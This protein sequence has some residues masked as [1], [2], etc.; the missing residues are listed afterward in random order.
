MSPSPHRS[1]SILPLRRAAIAAAL[2]A[3]VVTA[4]A[5]GAEQAKPTPAPPSPLSITTITVTPAA[6]GPDTLCQLRVELRNGGDRIASELAFAVK[7]NGQEL[8][9]YRNQLF[10]QR[11]D[12]G[13]T[14]TVRLYNFW[15]TETG[16]PAPA[17]G[18]YRVEVSLLAARW[19]QVAMEKD[20]EVWT[21]V[22]AVP[23]LPVSAQATAGK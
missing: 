9:V 19:Y 18:K 6:P 16:R 13:K 17:D 2:A 10:M 12:P 15:T 8:P 20:V 1:S 3:L 21:P 22:G 11:L 14:A 4:T 23:G 5:Y 7:L